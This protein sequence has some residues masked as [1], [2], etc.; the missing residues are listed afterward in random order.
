MDTK[1]EWSKAWRHAKEDIRKSS[2]SQSSETESK[3]EKIH[4]IPSTKIQ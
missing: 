1:M 4:E 3:I 2:E